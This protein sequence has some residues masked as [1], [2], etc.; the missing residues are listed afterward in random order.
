MLWYARIVTYSGARALFVFR[1]VLAILGSTAVVYVCVFLKCLFTEILISNFPVR[2]NETREFEF[3]LRHFSPF[4]GL[5]K[6]AFQGLLKFTY[7]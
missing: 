5:M 3:Y 2:P 7:L 1:G 6:V 4:A